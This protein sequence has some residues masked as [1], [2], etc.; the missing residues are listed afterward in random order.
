ML[1]RDSPRITK[2][3]PLR[4]NSRFPKS[5]QKMPRISRSKS[6]AAPT[7]QAPRQPS[8][9]GYTEQKYAPRK[10]IEPLY[11]LS[12]C[13]LQYLQI[14]DLDDAPA[15]PKGFFSAFPYSNT[16]HHDDYKSW[17]PD[18]ASA[19][20]F[21]NIVNL[22]SIQFVIATR[23]HW[24]LTDHHGIQPHYTFVAQAMLRDGKRQA[25]WVG[26][27]EM[28][29]AV[30]YTVVVLGENEKRWDKV[31]YQEVLNLLRR[32]GKCK[33]T[34]YGESRKEEDVLRMAQTLG[35]AVDDTELTDSPSVE[36]RTD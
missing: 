5:D 18:I 12:C 21:I 29:V 32:A 20:G 33:F 6:S 1:L 14:L 7:E 15:A 9:P 35:T 11:G 19:C 25:I 23:K 30:Q 17:S 2:A 24:E 10:P 4:D 3:V 31:T 34:T 13:L 22:A 16:V 27:V 28:K 8:P 36:S 26:A